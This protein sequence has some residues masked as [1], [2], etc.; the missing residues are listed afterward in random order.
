MKARRMPMRRWPTSLHL[1]GEVKHPN[2]NVEESKMGSMVSTRL[3]VP[4]DQSIEARYESLIRLA[5][6][7]RAQHETKTLFRVLVGE[8][9]PVIPFDAIAQYDES[10]KKV[11]WHF[12]E[13]CEPSR[14]R[15][16]DGPIEETL[17]W[18]V[19]ENQQAA[20]ITD[21][22]PESR[23]SHTAEQF[24]KAGLRSGSGVPLS[25]AHRQLGNRV[26]ASRDIDPNSE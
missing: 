18:W 15:S 24:N 19:F 13:S 16:S 23:F 26:L 9:R 5:D 22:R 2:H 6:S 11:N 8:L 25:T 12:C 4:S 7:I 21:A 20:G 1:Q 14:P 10:S 3:E 17:A